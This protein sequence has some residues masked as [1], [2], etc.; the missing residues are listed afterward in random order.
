[1]GL[2]ITQAMEKGLRVL[3]RHQR[4]GRCVDPVIG[5]GQQ[6]A[7]RRAAGQQGQRLAFRIAE[8]EG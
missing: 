6:K 8:R 7:Q 5:P 4:I 2:I 1:M 3:A